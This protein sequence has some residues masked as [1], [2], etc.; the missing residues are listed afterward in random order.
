[1]AEVTVTCVG[2]RRR[3]VG[4]VHVMP[5]SEG[6]AVT[7]IAVNGICRAC[8]FVLLLQ[9]QR[10]QEGFSFVVLH[11]TVVIR[12]PPQRGETSY[13]SAEFCLGDYDRVWMVI[14]FLVENTG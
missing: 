6:G 9:S 12:V 3:V 4:D 8:Q 2:S 5:S 13:D 11:I 7:G 1:M 10:K 14:A